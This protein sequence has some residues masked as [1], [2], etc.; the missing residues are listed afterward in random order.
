MGFQ[1]SFTWSYDPFNIISDLR[2][3]LKT[4]PYNHTPRPEIEKFRNQEQWEE[5]TLQE[6]K[7][8]VLPPSTLRTPTSQTN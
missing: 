8:Q 5:N 6:A 2:V 4:T 1:L 3:E 7:E